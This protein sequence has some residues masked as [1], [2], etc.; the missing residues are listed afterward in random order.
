[1]RGNRIHRATRPTVAD[2]QDASAPAIDLGTPLLCSLVGL[3]ALRRTRYCWQT[4][5]FWNS[6]AH[7][8]RVCIWPGS[9][10]P[11]PK[12]D[13]REARTGNNTN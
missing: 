11:H 9:I 8:I 6:I 10:A 5:T 3:E 1:M 12:L 2:W 4:T 7:A 13:Y